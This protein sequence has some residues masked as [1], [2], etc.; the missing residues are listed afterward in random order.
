MEYTG[1][2][3]IKHLAWVLVEEVGLDAFRNL[4]RNP[5]RELKVAPF[6]GCYILR[7]SWAL[8]LDENPGREQYLEQII[9]GL[10][11]RSR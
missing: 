1:R 10:R 8:G 9:E 5:L 3:V 6:Y 7:P 4:V 11:A 2:V